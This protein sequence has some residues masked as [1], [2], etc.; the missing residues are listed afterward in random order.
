MPSVAKA[1]NTPN[2]LRRSEAKTI[3]IEFAR[4]ERDLVMFSRVEFAASRLRAFRAQPKGSSQLKSVLTSWP[5][6]GE[7]FF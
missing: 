3:R 2:K 4:E 1:G 6:K 7:N 5:A